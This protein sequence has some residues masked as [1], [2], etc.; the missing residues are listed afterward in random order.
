MGT[1]R[2]AFTILF[3]TALVLAGWVGAS[4]YL[5][6]QNFPSEGV[7]VDIPHGASRRAVA[8]LLANQG[9]VRSRWVFEALSRRRSRSTLQAGEYFFDRPVTAFEVFETIAQG[10]VYVRE[11]VIPEGYSMFDIAD[12]VAREG[13]TSRD[14]FLAAARDPTAV[15]DLA[16][17]AV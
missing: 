1:V 13:F 6:Y 12:L 5:P 10:R 17:N 14:D 11:L 3:L 16:P 7:F 4:L 8:R 15:R 2:R 9:V